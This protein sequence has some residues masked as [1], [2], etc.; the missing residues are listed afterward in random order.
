[1]ERLLVVGIGQ[2]VERPLRVDVP[3]QHLDV[4]LVHGPHDVRLR[5]LA[6]KAGGKVFNRGAVS[7]TV[8]VGREEGHGGGV[9]PE[10]DTAFDWFD[11]SPSGSDDVSEGPRQWVE[12]A[13]HAR[14]ERRRRRLLTLLG[15]IWYP[16]VQ[17]CLEV[18]DDFFVT[19]LRTVGSC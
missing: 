8:T 7:Q 3:Q 10:S 9:N 14:Y 1:G 6:R 5:T 4:R 2:L 12:P 16:T 15:P 11:H 17:K 18:L 19:H 13:V